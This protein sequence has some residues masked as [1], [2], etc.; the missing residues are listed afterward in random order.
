MPGV[1][2]DVLLNILKTYAF[3]NPELEYCLG[4]NYVVGFLLS[5]FKYEEVAFK[6]L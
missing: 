3:Y 4:M 2:M 1:N 6:A 5:V